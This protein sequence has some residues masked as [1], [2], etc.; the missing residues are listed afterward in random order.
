M[1]IQIEKPRLSVP[2]CLLVD[3]PA[4]CINPF[5]YFRL[6]VDREGH[7][8]HEPCIPLDF[9][10]Q[11]VGICRARGIR[12]KFS[13]LPY[14][15]GLGSIL[16]GWEGCHRA[17]LAAWLELARAEIAPHF[18]ITPEILTHTLAL[19]LRTRAL[20]PQPEHDWMAGLTRDELREYFG[21]ALAILKAAGF[22]PAG[23]TQPCYF[24]GSREVYAAAALAAIQDIGGPPITFYF[25]DG[26]FE[27][28]PV[29][30]LE[31]ILLDRARGEAVVNIIAYCNDH[32]WPT[33][34]VTSKRA[35]QVVDA[36]ISADGSGGRLAELAAADE[37][38]TFVCH[39]QTLYSDGSRQGLVALDEVAARL[40]RAHG[41]RLLWLTPSE[42][43]RYRAASETCWVDVQAQGDGWA[44]EVDAAFDCPDFTISVP[45][46]LGAVQQVQLIA[47]QA[48][49]RALLAVRPGVMAS[50]LLPSH[51]WRQDYDRVSLCF[52]LRR[53]RQIVHLRR[54]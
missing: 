21:A 39:W 40:A 30:P 23:I 34:R 32:F 42:I 27:P 7:E 43:A 36:L 2:A 5:Y 28:P 35:D 44:I 15:A 45:M 22:M 13:V 12:G 47:G 46:P 50:G 33:Q 53:G 20:L 10:E 4:P 52:D 11:F 31:A 38:L 49:D 19:D 51:A 54:H 6:Q 29:P 37:W 24:N 9:L 41:P 17:E 8:R 1:H 25:I 18:D 3:D 14:P 16:D 48:A 26:Y